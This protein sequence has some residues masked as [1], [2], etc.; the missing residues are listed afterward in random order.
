MSFI[1]G[2]FDVACADCCDKNEL[3]QEL[4]E[5]QVLIILHPSPNLLTKIPRGVVAK[6]PRS[7]VAR[8]PCGL[9]LRG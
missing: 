9:V 6:L 8:F 5:T 2:I 4:I 1:F 3:I 7:H